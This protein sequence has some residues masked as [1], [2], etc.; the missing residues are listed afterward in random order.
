MNLDKKSH[1]NLNQEP[2]ILKILINGTFFWLAV[3]L[4][5]GNSNAGKNE[6]IAVVSF[7]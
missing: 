1:K 7:R 6:R 5:L 3:T 4:T 2:N